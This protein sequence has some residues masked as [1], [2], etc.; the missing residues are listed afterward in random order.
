MR[1][2]VRQLRL[3]SRRGSPQVALLL[4]LPLAFAAVS[5][6]GCGVEEPSVDLIAPDASRAGDYGTLGP[7]GARVTR[8]ALSSSAGSVDADVTMPFGLDDEGPFLP[9][10][11][12]QGGF[13]PVERYRWLGRHLASRGFL[14]L[15]PA[16]AL[17]LAFFQQ[18]N[19]LVALRGA[20]AASED[21]DDALFELLRDAPSALLGHS[22]GG[23]VAG[24]VWN[25]APA[26][27]LRDL[28]LL[29]SEPD[30]GT[31]FS[32]R[33]EGT[34]LS[35]SGSRDE[36]ITPPEV[37]AGALAFPSAQVAI[38]DGMNHYQ[39]TDDPKADELEKDGEPTIDVDEARRRTMI[40]V[41]ALL[42]AL[43]GGTAYPFA[44]PASWPEGL[45]PPD[46]LNEL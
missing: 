5:G 16:H 33:T 13:V 7:Y 31:D 9:V 37:A 10:V 3:P 1:I 17:D 34:V 6:T 12:V 42:E 19:G 36:R 35:I 26:D 22:L 2:A 28:V 32:G 21:R 41:D 14:V 45:L 30:P 25:G 29:A 8:R 38:V 27:E 20:K 40:L 4:A 39:L 44:D 24:N 43:S 11:F 23:V 18:E 46:E 15:S